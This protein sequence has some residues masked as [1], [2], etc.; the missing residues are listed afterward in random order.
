[1]REG[2]RGKGSGDGE[3]GSEIEVKGVEM[4]GRGE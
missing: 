1:M 2:K 3:I 4:R